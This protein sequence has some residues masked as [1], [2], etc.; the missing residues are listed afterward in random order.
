MPSF[1]R[2]S[3]A[4]SP[5]LQIVTHNAKLLSEGKPFLPESQFDRSRRDQA[6]IDQVLYALRHVNTFT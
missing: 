3:P 2:I 6:V 1:Y 5:L 4:I